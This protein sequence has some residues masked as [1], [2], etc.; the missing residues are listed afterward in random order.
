MC[1]EFLYPQQDGNILRRIV[2]LLFRHIEPLDT[3]DCRPDVGPRSGH[4]YTVPTDRMH[5]A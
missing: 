3:N 5:R 1:T 4:H 2:V